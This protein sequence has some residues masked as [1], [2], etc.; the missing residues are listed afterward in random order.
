MDL[1]R[2]DIIFP[3]TPELRS[4]ARTIYSII[5]KTKL[6]LSAKSVPHTLSVSCTLGIQDAE[7]NTL[8]EKKGP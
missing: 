5:P 2:I 1:S 4:E 6:L 8:S 3:H 7:Y